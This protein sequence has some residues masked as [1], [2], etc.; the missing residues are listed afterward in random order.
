MMGRISQLGMTP[1]RWRLL[2]PFSST[3]DAVDSTIP[4]YLRPAVMRANGVRRP[5]SGKR[6]VHQMIEAY[7]MWLDPISF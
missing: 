6:D 4:L 5:E 3:S 2:F 1:Y 7:P